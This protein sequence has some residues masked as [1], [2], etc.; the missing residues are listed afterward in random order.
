MIPRKSFHLWHDIR[1]SFTELF[2]PS[3]SY[4]TGHKFAMLPLFFAN[5]MAEFD[6]NDLR[7]VFFGQ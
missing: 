1:N 7:F 3:F 5:F 4:S 6:V 2:M